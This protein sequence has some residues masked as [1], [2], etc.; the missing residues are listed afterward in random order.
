MQVLI[1][2][3]LLYN[4]TVMISSLREVGLRWIFNLSSLVE[5]P[6]PSFIGKLFISSDSNIVFVSMHQSIPY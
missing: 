4:Q 1:C 2:S 3:K 5:Y 6:L